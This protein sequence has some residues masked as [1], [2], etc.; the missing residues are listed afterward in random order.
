VSA[1]S[2]RAAYSTISNNIAGIFGTSVTGTGNITINEEMPRNISKAMIDY[3]KFLHNI[4]ARNRTG[5]INI[6]NREEALYLGNHSKI[7]YGLNKSSFN[8]TSNQ[9]INYY[10]LRINSSGI[11][12]IT[13][14]DWVWSTEGVY[15]NLTIKDAIDNLALINNSR[16]GYV[17]TSR[18]NTFNITYTNG[19]VLVIKLKDYLFV[20]AT[21]PINTS[22]TIDLQGEVYTGY[23]VRINNEVLDIMKEYRTI[24]R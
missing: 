14:S 18:L 9:S 3:E 7:T 4:Y 19:K 12:N 20:N 17:N 15:V 16:N 13:A 21:L 8:L 10:S 6:T 11:Q 5:I 24:V 2:D 23:S 22:M 1:R